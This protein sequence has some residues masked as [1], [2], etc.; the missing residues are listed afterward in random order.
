MGQ[1]SN[2]LKGV[3]PYLLQTNHHSYR[4]KVTEKIINGIKDIEN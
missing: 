3:K 2:D 1:N 4:T